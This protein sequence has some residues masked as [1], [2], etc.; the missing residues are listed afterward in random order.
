MAHKETARVEAFSDG[1]F[2]IAITLLI[3]EIH[4]PHLSEDAPSRDLLFAIL[5]LWPSLL[6]LLLRFLVVLVMWVNHHELAR[7]VRRVN[8]PLLFSNGFLLLMTTFDPFPTA[9]LAQYLGTNAAK[10]G[11]RALSRNVLH[12]QLCIQPSLGSDCA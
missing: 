12:R 3:L 5:A 2:A 4:V 1:D 7:L 8:Y 9:V 6:A 10:R 11:S